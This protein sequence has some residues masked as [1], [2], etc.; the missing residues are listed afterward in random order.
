MRIVELTDETKNNLL[1]SLLKRSPNSY[2]QYEK[3]VNDI[4]G[5]V[6]A[7]RDEA[8]FEYTSKC[9]KGR[10]RRGLCTA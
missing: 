1:E 3:T 4:I 2:G 5:D 7:R 8:L 9:Y 6:R 10:N